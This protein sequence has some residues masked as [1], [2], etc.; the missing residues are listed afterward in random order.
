MRQEPTVLVLEKGYFGGNWAVLECDPFLFPSVGVGLFSW[1]SAVG[2]PYPLLAW[3]SPSG[4]ES[5]PQ[6]LGLLAQ[7]LENAGW[8]S[9][10]ALKAQRC[11]LDCDCAA[12]E[13]VDPAFSHP[14]KNSDNN[15]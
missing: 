3:A 7:G 13:C 5:V 14:Q 10:P 2:L 12:R 9:R 8:I 6:P 15:D 11:D 1:A 4:A